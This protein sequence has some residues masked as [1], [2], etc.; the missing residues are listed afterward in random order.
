M[1]IVIEPSKYKT[2]TTVDNISKTKEKQVLS[3]AKNDLCEE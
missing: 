1:I 2:K 3:S